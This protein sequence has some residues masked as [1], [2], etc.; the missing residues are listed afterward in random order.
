MQPAD[1]ADA[2]GDSGDDRATSARSLVLRQ[3]GFPQVRQHLRRR[4]HGSPLARFRRGSARL[5]H[6]H[7]RN[8][9]DEKGK[10][11][12]YAILSDRHPRCSDTNANVLL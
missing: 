3:G 8:D 2:I 7:P 12:L 9:H 4:E 10:W 5:F 6:S 1:T 11:A